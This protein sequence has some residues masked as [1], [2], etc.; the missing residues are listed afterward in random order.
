[1]FAFSSFKGA[2]VKM[3]LKDRIFRKIFEIFEKC[4]I[5]KTALEKKYRGRKTVLVLIC[6]PFHSWGQMDV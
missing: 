3:K 1:M 2:S 5:E 4:H 6:F